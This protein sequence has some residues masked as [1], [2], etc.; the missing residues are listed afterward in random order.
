[1]HLAKPPSLPTEMADFL[2]SL[3]CRSNV[4]LADAGMSVLSAIADFQLAGVGLYDMLRLELMTGMEE[5]RMLRPYLNSDT[6]G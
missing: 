1:M 5:E 2:W 4:V 6:R 3:M